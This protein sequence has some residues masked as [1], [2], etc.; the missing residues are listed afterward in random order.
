MRNSISGAVGRLA[1]ASTPVLALALIAMQPAHAQTFTALYTF[2]GGTDGGT[3]LAT[4]LLSNGNICGTTSGGTH[5]NGTVLR[6]EFQ[7]PPQDRAAL[8]RG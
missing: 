6:T 1:L 8:L 7:Q 3:P 5:A 2:K 4:P